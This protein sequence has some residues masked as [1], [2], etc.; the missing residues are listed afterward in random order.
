MDKDLTNENQSNGLKI[1]KTVR[2]ID[3]HFSR[4]KVDFFDDLFY[5]RNKMFFVGALDHV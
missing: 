1:Q 3:D 2:G 5:G 4:T